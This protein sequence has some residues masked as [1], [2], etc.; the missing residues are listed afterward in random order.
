MIRKTGQAS[1]NSRV[2]WEYTG[3]TGTRSLIKSGEGLTEARNDSEGE[4]EERDA[5]KARGGK[6]RLKEEPGAF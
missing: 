1:E 5:P 4:V 6:I 2:G 3:V